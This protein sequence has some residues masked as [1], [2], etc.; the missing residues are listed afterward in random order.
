MMIVLTLSLAG[1]GGGGSSSGNSG[2]SGSTGNNS[3]STGNNTGGSTPTLATVNGF[4]LDNTPSHNP[5]QGAL[6]TVIVSGGTNRTATTAADGSFVVTN[7]ALTATSFKVASP[8]PVAY[9][10]YADY[11]PNGSLYDLNACTL[12]LPTLVAG[13]N[14]LSSDIYMFLGG[15]NPPPPPPTGGCPA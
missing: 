2:N 12:P 11:G 3:G 8:N 1:C 10:N 5:V 6:V 4:V 9:Y 15:T 13:A 14:T 7:V